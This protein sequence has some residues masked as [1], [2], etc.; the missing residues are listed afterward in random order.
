MTTPRH[1]TRQERLIR[2]AK[3][4]SDRAAQAILEADREFRPEPEA[5]PMLLTPWAR[6]AA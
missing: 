3:L 4:R 6:R 5:P 1:L 2:L